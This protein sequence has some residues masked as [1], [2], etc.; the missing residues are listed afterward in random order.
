[1]QMRSLDDQPLLRST[2]ANSHTHQDSYSDPNSDSDPNKHPYPNTN[3]NLHRY[4]NPDPKTRLNGDSAAYHHRGFLNNSTTRV[5][6]AYR[7]HLDP[8]PSASTR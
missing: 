1:M 6:L 3:C 7:F 8:L 5:R 2:H 4:C